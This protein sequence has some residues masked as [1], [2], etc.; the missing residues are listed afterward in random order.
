MELPLQ[1]FECI[2]EL[3][4]MTRRRPRW[5]GINILANALQEYREQLAWISHSS[6]LLDE[7]VEC[8]VDDFCILCEGVERFAQIPGDLRNLGACGGHAENRSGIHQCSGKSYN[9]NLLVESLSL[10]VAV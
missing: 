3:R 8:L 2:A 10:C 9:W 6:D 1:H 5:V 7:G 4:P